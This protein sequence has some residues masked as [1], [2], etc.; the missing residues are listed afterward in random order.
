MSETGT[1]T[2]Y[3]VAIVGGGAAGIATAASL[4]K[5]RPKLSIA[6]IEPA[7]E[8]YYQPAYTLVGNGVFRQKKTV[9][10]MKSVMPRRAE[11]IKSS[12][13]FFEPNNSQVVLDDG[14]RINYRMLVVAPGLKLDWDA[15]EGLRETLGKNGVTSNYAFDLAPYTWELVKGLK[16]GNALFSQP[17]MPFK[18]AGAP[19]KAMYLS[20]DYWRR[21]RV[22]K[23]INVEFNSAAPGLF[24]VEY[25][26]PSL[27]KYVEKYD[28]KL[29]F[30]SNLKSVDGPGGKATFEVMQEDGSTQMVE[31][32]FDMLHVV[33]P[34]TAPDFIRTSPLANEQGWVEVD[35]HTLR[36]VRYGNVFSLG[37][38]MSASN[39]KT[40][41]AVR[42][43]APIVAENLLA[44]MD[45]KESEFLYNG[46]GS[47]PLTVQRGKIIM[48]EFGYGGKLLPTLPLESSKPRRL[49]WFLKKRVIPH[50]YWDWMLKGKERF[51]SSARLANPTVD[52]ADG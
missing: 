19:Q 32:D 28:I 17:P 33:P 35:Q 9:R 3:D 40:A 11:W 38:V 43:Q 26:V 10:P 51:I 21:K 31:K 34:Q 41:A 29:A 46:Y 49:N 5:R 8:H 18:C 13:A 39:A 37:D 44:I 52:S 50:I 16:N 15:V 1:E 23:D 14:N 4:F 27:M 47:C 6:I 22:L 20:A 45:G 12:V 7:E 36:S 30:K 42:Q 48:A 2:I 24:G 25:Y